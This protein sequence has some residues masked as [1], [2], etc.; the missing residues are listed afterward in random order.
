MLF[1]VSVLGFILFLLLSV[2]AQEASHNRVLG[3]EFNL[4]DGDFIPEH[5]PDI[6][7]LV[8]YMSVEDAISILQRE[9]AGAQ[10]IGLDGVMA[11]HWGNTSGGEDVTPQAAAVQTLKVDERGITWQAGSYGDLFAFGFE[12][13]VQLWTRF[14]MAMRD[15]CSGEDSPQGVV[16][17]LLTEDGAKDVFE[18]PIAFTKIIP[19]YP[20]RLPTHQGKGVA[21]NLGDPGVF[22]EPGSPE[23]FAVCCFSSTGSSDE[24]EET[25]LSLERLPQVIA[26]FERL[27]PRLETP[28]L[29]GLLLASHF[30]PD[31]DEFED[32]I[33]FCNRDGSPHNQK[34]ALC[35]YSALQGLAYVK[36]TEA[37]MP[38]YSTVCAKEWPGDYRGQGE[39]IDFTMMYHRLQDNPA[40][41]SDPYLGD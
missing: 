29:N 33:N 34:T 2:V 8:S 7:T 31:A 40:T 9:L 39:C 13:A 22:S 1:R 18:D 3:P 35:Q 19:R 6:D 10:F 41:N 23:G 12:S 4:Y 32:I 11:E 38:K 27:S 21:R 26:A 25:H 15:T 36:H 28:E 16:L 24:G 14:S 5:H 30:V 37:T 17:Y 20:T